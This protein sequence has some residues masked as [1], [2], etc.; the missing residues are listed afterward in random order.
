VV[1]LDDLQWIDA[2]SL[3]LIQHLFMA[4]DSKHVLLVGAYRDNEVGPAHPLRVTLESIRETHEPTNDILLGPLEEPQ[5]RQ[6]IADSLPGDPAMT[7]ALSALVFEKTGGNP[8]YSLEFLQTLY[9]DNLLTLDHGTGLWNCAFDQVHSL[10]MTENVVD[11]LIKR[12]QTLEPDAQQVLKLAACLGNTFDLQA[13]SQLLAP[14]PVSGALRT[15]IDAG[16][17]QPI[18]DYHFQVMDPAIG[19]E[20]GGDLRS[21]CRFQHD[22][23]QQAAYSLIEEEERQRTHLA[24]GERFREQAGADTAALDKY[25]FDI[26]D[27]LNLAEELI[28]SSSKRLELAAFNL[29]AGRKAKQNTAYSAALAYLEAGLQLLPADHWSAHYSL[30]YD[31]SLHHAECQYLDGKFDR[32]EQSCDELLAAAK[33][34][35]DKREILNLK[36]VLYTSLNKYDEAIQT[37]IDAARLLGFKLPLSPKRL[38]I[39]REI[40]MSRWLLRGKSDDDLMALPPMTSERH[41]QAVELFMNLMSPAFLSNQQ[42]AILLALKMF[43]ISLQKGSSNA[44]PYGFIIYAVVNASMDRFEIGHQFGR[45]ALQLNQKLN[46]VE[47][48][49]RLNFLF[50]TAVNHWK[51]P[52]AEN[53]EYLTTAYNGSMHSGDFLYA[54]YSL[55]TL[56]INSFF[57][58]D[59]LDQVTAR[60]EKYLA[61]FEQ[62]KGKNYMETGQGQCA[63]QYRLLLRALEG[64]THALNSM[65]DEEFEE[66]AFAA[67]LLDGMGNFAYCAAKLHLEFIADDYSELPEAATEGEKWLGAIK[68]TGDIRIPDYFF[69]QALIGAR[70]YPDSSPRQQKGLH[71]KLERN[72]ALLKNWA[73][74]SPDNFASR[75]HLVEAEHARVTGDKVRAMHC[76]DVAIKEAREQGFT[77]IEAVGNELAAR[78]HLAEGREKVGRVYLLEARYAYLKWGAIAKVEALDAAYPRLQLQPGSSSG[79]ATAGQTAISGG[80]LDLQAFMKAAE[81]LSGEIVLENLL[82]KLLS[83]VI[84]I[85]GANKGV[86]IMDHDGALLVEGV[87]RIDGDS[88]EENIEVLQSTPVS[89]VEGL[90]SGVIN[91]VA[92]T[93]ENVVLND[94]AEDHRFADDAY[95]SSRQSK[96]ILSTPLMLQGKLMGLLYLENE[97]TT[98]A[99]TSARVE[100]LTLLSGQA[101]IS[102]QNAR[103]YARQVDLTASAGR[104]V[105][106]E[107]LRL[108][109]RNS[110]DEVRLGDSLERDM[111]ILVSDIRGFT[112][113]SEHMTPQESFE[114]INIY[115]SKMGPVIRNHNGFV[116]K[117]TGDGM[118]AF[119]PTS[120]DD[121][122]QASVATLKELAVYNQQRETG[123]DAPIH[124]GIGLH[125]GTSMLGIVGEL[126]RMQFDA[127]SDAANLASR[128]ESLTK[129]FGATIVV[130]G[131]IME[132]LSGVD[133]HHQRSLGKVLVKGRN[134]PVPIFDIFGGDSAEQVTLK[135]E[136]REDFETGLQLYSQQRF[137]QACVHFNAVIKKNP[138]DK[139]ATLYLKESAR[140]M[141][142]GVPEG[143]Q[144]APVLDEK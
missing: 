52:V 35:D 70:L 127:M 49:H 48:D 18:S 84:T 90:P 74:S 13:L 134:T 88:G 96:S 107:F 114:F 92:R 68:V 94:L 130:S 108:L 117:Y 121:A 78:F 86:L 104:F 25:L 133:K 100:F 9:R 93:A 137:D 131:D 21:S 139:A 23:V 116:G 72:L 5:L 31:L 109:N 60:C 40:L 85:G 61:F 120:A 36:I 83:I 14:T 91:Y 30:S 118:M 19:E 59:P 81:A 1:F 46:N 22:R 135:S 123:G 132:S 101:A 97:L 51:K 112:S 55:I 47:I 24:I 17:V 98:H 12:M 57:K 45:L 79:G 62:V 64:K 87:G 50:A 124:I 144:E 6:L 33:S 16:L 71:K 15:L 20:A 138:A 75:C 67:Q 56:L 140:F 27:H 99:F 53:L 29:S 58:G 32:A 38:D 54:D 11:L 37:G 143:W 115:L 43:N 102:L 3:N 77:Q 39:G 80:N 141:L 125:T 122:V 119:F 28:T 66:Q 82:R 136:T 110:L 89:E 42:L 7:E 105:P 4:R 103:L 63:V 113:I 44:T 69:Y 111:V 76:Y 73:A 142:D 10:Q 106:Y 95:F 26:T 65:S 129:I 2:A 8:Y 41:L 126:E 34:D 128:L